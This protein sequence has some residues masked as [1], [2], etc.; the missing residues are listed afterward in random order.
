MKKVLTL[1]LVIG[2][3]IISFSCKKKNN[4]TEPEP[5]QSYEVIVNPITKIMDIETRNAITAIDTSNFTFTFNGNSALLSELELGDILVDSASDMAKYGYLRKVTKITDSKGELIIETEQGKLAEAVP[6]GSIR[7]ESNKLKHSQ[8]QSIELAKGVSFLSSDDSKFQAFDFEYNIEMHD[9]DYPNEKIMILGH[10]SFSL[11][12]IIKFDWTFALD[13]DFVEVDL[14]KTAIKI[15][16]AASIEA[17]AQNGAAIQERI[18]FAKMVFTPW[19]FSVGPVPVTVSPQIELFIEASG[20]VGASF[21]TFV[22]EK[23]SGEIGLEYTSEDGWNGIGESDADI[24]FLPPALYAGCGFQTHVGPEAKLLFYGVAGPFLDITGC[25]EIEAQML[26]GENWNLEFNVGA[27]SRAGTDLMLLGY[28]LNYSTELFC[29]KET[30]FSLSNEPFGNTI[31]IQ[32]PVDGQS[33]ALDKNIQ[34]RTI[35]TGET[36]S[37]VE[38]Y[39][40]N[41]LIG[42]DMFP[43]YEYDWNTSSYGEGSHSLQTKALLLISNETIESD[44]VNITL[45]NASWEVIDMTGIAGQNDGTSNKDV[46]FA[47]GN[48]GW[49]IG[50]AALGGYFL[51]TIDGGNSWENIAPDLWITPINQMLYLNNDKQLLRMSEGSIFNAGIWDRE[52]GFP[53]NQGN[54]VNTFDNLKIYDLALD[55]DGM[56]QSVGKPLGNNTYYVYEANSSTNEFT[57]ST[58]IDYY[59]PFPPKIYFFRNKGIV[60]NIKSEDTPLKQFY[61]ITDNGGSSWETKEFNVSGLTQTDEIIDACFVDEDKGWLVGKENYQNAFVLITEDG[62]QTWEKVSVTDVP[63]FSSVQFVTQSE[64]YATVSAWGTEGTKL[65]HTF[66]GGLTWEPVEDILTEK[67]MNKVF[68]LGSELGMVVGMGTDIYRYTVGK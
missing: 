48:H 62:G 67:G 4:E 13:W 9:P 53:D 25:Y 51:E 59:Y 49:L 47:D 37:K 20:A 10:A 23:Y 7:F 21:N 54:W 58:Q 57:G 61:M 5:E 45:Q 44:I 42:T 40:D 3:L 14:F 55:A 11:E 35:S 66:D 19:T 17:H 56:I 1:I 8:L 63:D 38:F 28:R 64:G 24:T 2:I 43:P 65:Y 6:Q 18:S 12:T 50:G 31:S 30:V 60:Y 27:R 34:I 46:F 39:V 68:F 16:Q 22:T 36:P 29:F 52:L 41:Q 15:E 26:T 33:Y 32:N